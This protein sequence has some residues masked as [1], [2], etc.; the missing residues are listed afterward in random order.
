MNTFA[1]RVK[2]RRAEL[3][4][5][6]TQ[7]ARK[8]GLSQ[9]TISDIERGRNEGS[10]EIVALAS[11]LSCSAEWLKTGTGA[12]IAGGMFGDAFANTSPGPGVVGK[13]PL[14]S[15]VQAGLFCTSPDLFEPGDAEVWIPTIKKYG[16][17]AYALRVVGDSMVLPYPSKDSIFPGTIIFVDP[18]KP[19]TN[20]AKVIARIEGTDEATCKV[21]KE[22]MGR[23]FLNPQNPQYPVIEMDETMHICGVVVGRYIEE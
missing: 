19:L 3:G 14:I 11:A 21:F 13:I 10:A 9:T 5:N 16:P 8:A 17:H 4:L 7:L 15:W 6:Q 1:T 18:D 20:G 12:K 2:A 23:R 22:D